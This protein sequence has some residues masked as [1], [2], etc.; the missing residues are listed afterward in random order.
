MLFYVWHCFKGT[1]EAVS[2]SCCGNWFAA[3][4][5]S[6]AVA[7][8]VAAATAAGWRIWLLMNLLILYLWLI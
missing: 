7:V 2:L 6:A 1:G 3:A 4:P 8:V 5:R